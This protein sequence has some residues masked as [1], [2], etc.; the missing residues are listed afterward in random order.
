M[1]EQELVGIGA[2]VW[3]KVHI[4]RH[5][6]KQDL[7]GITSKLILGEVVELLLQS[8]VSVNVVVVKRAPHGEDSPEPASSREL[9]QVDALDLNTFEAVVSKGKDIDRKVEP[10][11]SVD[12]LGWD[13]GMELVYHDVLATRMEDEP[14]LD[15]VGI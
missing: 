6:F 1:R 8:L 3:Y 15:F 7:R 11:I 14:P 12:V 9:D 13:S 2:G 5:K 4:L 10:R